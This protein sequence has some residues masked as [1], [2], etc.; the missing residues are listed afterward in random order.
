MLLLDAL[1]GA[2]VGAAIAAFINRLLDGLIIGAICGAV[3]AVPQYL[4]L[5]F[6]TS[7]SEDMVNKCV[8]PFRLYALICLPIF[9]ISLV[10]AVIVTS[11]GATYLERVTTTIKYGALVAAILFVFVKIRNAV[12]KT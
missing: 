9:C 7:G 4:L 3:I 2:I 6:H 10:L 1:I 8:H 12:R 5:M 11:A